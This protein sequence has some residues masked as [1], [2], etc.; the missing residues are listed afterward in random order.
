MTSVRIT[1]KGGCKQT[2]TVIGGEVREEV[3]ACNIHKAAPEILSPSPPV[4]LTYHE[5]GPGN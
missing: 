1:R 3:Q 2:F 4:A 5:E